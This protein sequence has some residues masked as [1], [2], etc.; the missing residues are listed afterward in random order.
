MAK[1]VGALLE[2]LTAGDP[3]AW[4][5]ARSK[6]DRVSLEGIDLSGAALADFDLSLADLTN[7]DLSEADLTGASFDESKLDG[8]DLTSAN[9]LEVEVTDA[10]FEGA[11]F[12]EAKVEGTFVHCNFAGSTWDGTMVRGARFIDCDFTD[13]DI[14]IVEAAG[15]NRFDRCQ[16]GD[17][18]DVPESLKVVRPVFLQPPMLEGERIDVKKITHEYADESELKR[19]VIGAATGAGWEPDM[20]AFLRD[21]T[22]IYVGL[23]PEASIDVLE[24]WIA[25][26]P[27]GTKMAAVELSIDP[28]FE[29]FLE[30]IIVPMFEGA[31]GDLEMIIEQD[32][33]AGGTAVIE[34]AIEAGR[35]K[36]ARQFKR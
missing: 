19:E 16:F 9:L 30:E 13:A 5:E 36:P 32:L 18:D 6:L 22:R 12:D 17:R 26:E 23:R 31:Q 8:A 11:S 14:D 35:V 29:T 20:V 3:N 4:N 27:R 10:S 33:E 7:A 25:F 34:M 24:E 15:G 28:G 1:A 2:V 21:G